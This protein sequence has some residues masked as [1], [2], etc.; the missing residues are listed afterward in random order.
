MTGQDV[1]ECIGGLKEV[2]EDDLKSRYHTFV[3]QD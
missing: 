3:T 2:T 1:T